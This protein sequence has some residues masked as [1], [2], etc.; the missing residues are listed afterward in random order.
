M[1]Q[2]GSK[3]LPFPVTAFELGNG[4]TV[5]GVDYDS[6]GICCLLHGRP[7]RVT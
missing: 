4:F 6:P 2:G 7:N 3:I 1:G 5:V